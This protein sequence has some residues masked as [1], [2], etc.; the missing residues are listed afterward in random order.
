M[1]VRASMLRL[2]VAAFF[3]GPLAA[4]AAAQFEAL[5][6]YRPDA[7]FVD[8]WSGF[9]AGGALG[10]TWGRF[11]SAILTP[12]P[13]RFGTDSSSV[14]VGLIGGAM[15]QYEN[16]VFGFEVDVNWGDLGFSRVISGVPV[17]AEADWHA[18]LR[19]R[20]GYAFDRVML[21]GT[22]GLA[23]G[24]VELSLPGARR[25]ASETGWTIG[26]GIETMLSENFTARAEYLYTD[27]GSTRGMLGGDPFS[28]EFDS[29]T[30]R[31]GVT[32]H[33]R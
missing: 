6:E 27:F 18:T 19:A 23:V 32:Y 13:A 31:A 17:T 29:H 28:A 10:A 1:S 16:L 4:P 33:F 24:R 7:S 14:A 21:Y 9:Y 26:A 20:A 11:D 2:L 8:R 15:A 5:D 25:R 3:M 30:V 22:G 12:P